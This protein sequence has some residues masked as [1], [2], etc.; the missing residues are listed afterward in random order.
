L[1]YTYGGVVIYMSYGMIR[2]YG[3]GQPPGPN[4]CPHT[5]FLQVCSVMNVLIVNTICLQLNMN[6]IGIVPLYHDHA[7][8]QSNV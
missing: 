1:K 7:K 4:N 3:S 2:A 8:K 5:Y 6:S